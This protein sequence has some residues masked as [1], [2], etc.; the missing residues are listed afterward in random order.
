MRVDAHVEPDGAVEAGALLEEDVLE[1]VAEGLG[2][3]IGR[4]VGVLDAPVGDR[5]GDAVDHLV[6]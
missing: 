6:D 4:E 2:V 5:I 3:F 1:L